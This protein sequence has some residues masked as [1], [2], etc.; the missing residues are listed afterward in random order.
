VVTVL[1]LALLAC[2]AF[3]IYCV[4]QTF[5]KR[6]RDIEHR[7]DLAWPPDAALAQVAGAMADLMQR[8]GFRLANQGPAGIVYTREYRSAWLLVPC[9]LLFP[10]G[11]LSL[12]F[13]SHTDINFTAAPTGARGSTI[14]VVGRG[15]QYVRD[16]ID[17]ILLDLSTQREPAAL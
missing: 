5:R 7:V 12:L 9:I 17:A 2:V 4:I 15:S 14:R 1:W 3:A 11:L 13:K 8:Q 6:N 10:I 16:Q